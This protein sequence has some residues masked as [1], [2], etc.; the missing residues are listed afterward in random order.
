MNNIIREFYDVEG[1]A[2]LLNISL[3]DFWH[4]VEIGQI[5]V[6]FRK[7][8]TDVTVDANGDVSMFDFVSAHTFLIPNNIAALLAVKGVCV[9][10]VALLH[11]AE[12][13]EELFMDMNDGKD[14]VGFVDT[15]R[16][17]LDSE[18]EISKS[19]IVISQISINKYL[20]KYAKLRELESIEKKEI[21]EIEKPLHPRTENNY[22]RLILTLCSDIKG[23]DAKKPHEAATLIVDTTGIKLDKETIAGYITK[24]YAL[25][26][27]SRD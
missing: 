8:I 10:K 2:S 5:E 6:S 15:H 11:L 3:S 18:L 22:L 13:R 19:D 9:T 21:I 26:I 4:L 23:F 14:Y 1:A 16:F 7:I 27:K 20:K 12:P 24:A 17:P 25:E